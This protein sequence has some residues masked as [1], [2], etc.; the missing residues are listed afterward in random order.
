MYA[1]KENLSYGSSSLL[2][3]YKTSP[4]PYFLHWH[5]E[6]EFVYVTRGQVRYT[7]NR[8][9]VMMKAGE[10]IFINGGDIHNMELSPEPGEAYILVINPGAF[11]Q[12]LPKVSLPSI[13]LPRPARPAS[14]AGALEKL[15]EALFQEYTAGGDFQE[16]ILL[17]L[18]HLLFFT[19]ARL[20]PKGE[21]LLFSER[22][23]RE[24]E[25]C[26]TILDFFEQ[27]PLSDYHLQNLAL[28]LG[29][30]PNH[31]CKV[32]KSIFHC[33]FYQYATELRLYRARELLKSTAL[34]IEEIA[35]QCGF[36]SSR[37]FLTAF[38]KQNRVPPSEYRRE[39][40]APQ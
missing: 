6:P 15:A 33:S 35:V 18:L 7:V 32:F 16:D 17:E 30:T 26:R 31:L 12:N 8:Q 34:S 13:Y 2:R 3:L 28:H 21:R 14:E 37:A 20:S 22:I 38:K 19:L 40:A 10:A 24:S 11:P 27:S 5:N 9:P 29:Y 4:G 1:Q 36:S 25:L 23:P 39:A